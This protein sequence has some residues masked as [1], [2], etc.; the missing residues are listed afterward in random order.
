MLLRGMTQTNFQKS[1]FRDLVL[2]STCLLTS[3]SIWTAGQ[4]ACGSK[5]TI[6]SLAK[7]PTI[8]Y[9]VFG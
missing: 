1:C 9:T 2:A 3:V 8:N 7:Y 6:E 5:R 4:F